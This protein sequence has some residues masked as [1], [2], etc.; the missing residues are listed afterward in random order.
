MF[1][2]PYVIKKTDNIYKFYIFLNQGKLFIQMDNSEIDEFCSSNDIYFS[3]KDI[4]GDYCYLNV[5]PLK[6][7]LKQFY[8]YT[9]NSSAECWRTFI[10][11]ENDSLNVNSTNPE[12]I[13][14]VINILLSL[15]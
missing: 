1:L 6:T 12:F 5:S 11:F 13:Q 9:E 3:K 14:P 7:N 15:L 4:I 10:Y 2:I 8:S